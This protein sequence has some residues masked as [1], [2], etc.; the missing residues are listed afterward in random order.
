M[1]KF[2]LANN[3]VINVD[4]KGFPECWQII[5]SA[6]KKIPPVT[7]YHNGY[8]TELWLRASSSISKVNEA[9]GHISTADVKI[10]QEKKGSWSGRTY[11]D[12]TCLD[13]SSIEV[14]GSAIERSSVQVPELFFVFEELFLSNCTAKFI[15][16]NDSSNWKATNVVAGTQTFQ[17]VQIHLG[18]EG[19]NKQKKN[20]V[21]ISL[22]F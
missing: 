1:T 13:A 7:L 4:T 17:M 9:R 6:A 19:L 22:I 10:G 20:R 14:Y 16:L 12:F 18:G 2:L 5:I 8:D 11:V 15:S 21:S 3:S